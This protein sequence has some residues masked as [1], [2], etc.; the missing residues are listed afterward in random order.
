MFRCS[1]PL[2]SIMP[3]AAPAEQRLTHLR[4]ALYECLCQAFNEAAHVQVH[5]SVEDFSDKST[6][7]AVGLHFTDVY[8]DDLCGA[9]IKKIAHTF[10]NTTQRN[11]YHQVYISPAMIQLDPRSPP[12]CTGTVAMRAC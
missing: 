11:N 2:P 8:D 7:H 12:V 5:D 1:S 4:T 3:S 10:Y 6:L 9:Y